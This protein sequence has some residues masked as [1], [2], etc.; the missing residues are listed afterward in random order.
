MLSK[1]LL[2]SVPFVLSTIRIVASD[3]ALRNFVVQTVTGQKGTIPS[4]GKKSYNAARPHADAKVYMP[5]PDCHGKGIV[6]VLAA[7]PDVSS[8]LENQ[9]KALAEKYGVPAEPI[10]H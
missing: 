3:P 5:C 6:P 8:D 10:T 4:P 7:A 9:W 1:L 2:A